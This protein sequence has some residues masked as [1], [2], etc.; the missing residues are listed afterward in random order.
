MA[1]C[2]SSEQVS[3]STNST[4]I[5]TSLG[6]ILQFHKTFVSIPNL[7]AN[8]ELM[9]Q[10]I[11]LV[12]NQYDQ[13]GFQ[14]TKL[15]S[16]T[17][18]I[19]LVEKT[20]DPSLKTVLFYFHIDGQP[21]NA[22][23][24]D[25]EDPFTPVLKEKKADGSW[26]AIDWNN[27]DGEI[28]DE[29]RIYARAA[30]D[31]K[32]PIT[33]MIAALRQMNESGSQPNFNIKIIFDP[34]EEYSSDALLS[35]LS[36]YKSR[37][38]ADYFIVMDG[39]SHDSNEPTVTFGCRGIATCSITAYGAK[40]PQHSGHF[41]NYIPNPVFDLSRLLAS[42]K[43]ESGRVLI[44]DYYNG[45]NLSNDISEVLNSVPYDAYSFDKGLG[46]HSSESVGSTYQEAL[47]YPTLNVR[48]IGTSWKGKGLKT[49]IPDN[50][51]AYID[52]RL[53]PETDAL[54]QM[55][56]IRAHIKEQGYYLTDKEPTDAERSSYRK[57]I[58]LETG[59]ALNAF[60]T[61]PNGA[62]GKSITS[63]LAKDFGKEP[64]K[65]RIMGGTVPIVPLINELGIPTI[66]VP[67]V[68]MDNNQHSPNENIR[69][70]NVRQGIEMCK[71]I[72]Q[73]EL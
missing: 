53:V 36:E 14:T 62:F 15:P 56:K 7:P 68:N 46:I 32:A 31:D 70:G 52:V 45:I 30:A 69:I 41:G 21:V 8:P 58:K 65:I 19:L 6:E 67:M 38:A 73:T 24:W 28:D 25:Q 9:L 49:V 40:T 5:G 64:I 33:M 35:T 2:T 17:L 66:I 27:L 72:L 48:Q 37:Y 16:S 34:E 44:K 47:Q 11:D 13:L 4:S 18:P 1:S 59:A 60:R 42:M 39:P 12:A 22:E 26:S 63:K 51:T 50:S 71:S 10:N 43:D 3:L 20:Y 54:V 55:D 23:A 29:W 57:I 61:D